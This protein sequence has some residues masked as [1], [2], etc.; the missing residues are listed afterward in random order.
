[1][2]A[3]MQHGASH[4]R[5]KMRTRPPHTHKCMRAHTLMHDAA[6]AAASRP[7][8]ATEAGGSGSAPP[9]PDAAGSGLAVVVPRPAAA[10][11]GLPGNYCYWPGGEQGPPAHH[12]PPRAIGCALRPRAKEGRTHQ[13]IGPGRRRTQARGGLHAAAFYGAEPG[14][15]GVHVAVHTLQCSPA[16]GDDPPPSFLFRPFAHP[17]ACFDPTALSPSP[18]P[19]PRCP[20][21]ACGP[22]TGNPRA[23]AERRR[24]QSQLAAWAGPGPLQLEVAC[25]EG[26]EAAVTALAEVSKA[27]ARAAAAWR[28]SPQRGQDTPCPDRLGHPLPLG[29]AAALPCWPGI[30]TLKARGASAA[31]CTWSAMCITA[32]HAPAP[33]GTMHA[34][35]PAQPPRR[36]RS[37]APHMSGVKPRM[38]DMQR[39]HALHPSAP[40]PDGT[41]SSRRH[42]AV[43]RASKQRHATRAGRHAAGWPAAR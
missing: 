7:A 28:S 22:C 38:H 27:S 19:P 37:N 36:P 11:T 18:A 10:R 12:A 9:A 2:C 23:E 26:L 8:D 5:T 4:A 3:C 40:H 16:C 29:T 14:G 1:M 41:I 39:H 33:C 30:P 25:L 42:R 35:Q 21:S 15:G 17:A 13:A 6:A 32:V 43:M 20:S 31:P 24:L 34:S